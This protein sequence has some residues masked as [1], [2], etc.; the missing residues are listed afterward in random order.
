MHR[1]PEKWKTMYRDQFRKFTDS[2]Q[3]DDHE[4]VNP[5]AQLLP[6]EL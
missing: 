3:K 6:S 2:P 1:S 4:Q 5:D